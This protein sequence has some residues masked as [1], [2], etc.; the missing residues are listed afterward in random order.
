MQ[1][2]SFLCSRLVSKP[3]VFN[4]LLLALLASAILF[5]PHSTATRQ[6]IPASDQENQAALGQ[7]RQRP[8]FVHGEALVRFKQ[9]RAFEGAASLP[10]PNADALIQTQD[11]SAALAQSQEQ[12]LVN[13]DRF[14]GSDIVDGLRMARMAPDDTMKAIAALQ[15]RDD[16]LYA[17]PNYIRHVDTTTP[18]DPQFNSLYGLTKIGAQQAWDTTTGSR[19][20]VVGI[21]DEGIDINHL[22]L[23]ANIWTNPSPGSISGISGD[24]HGYDF[25]TGSG[26]IPAEPH[27][28]HVAGT[29]GAVGNN[30]IGVAGVNWQVSLMSLRFINDATGSGSDADALKAYNYAKQMRDLW[31]SSG[32][33]KGANIRAL[34]ASYGGGGY[35]Q[36]SA[37]AINALGQSGILF[38]A[39]A[40]NDGRNTDVQ[41][42]YPSDYSLSSGVSVAATNSSDNL[43]GFS[44]F[45]TRTVM[46]GAP[47]VNICSTI[48]N[49]N[50]SCSFSGT[51]MAT[52]HVT[53]AAALLCAANPNLTVN[54]LRALLSF[55]GDVVSA[56]QG[57]SLS[58]RRLN[59]FKSLQ[60]M[61]EG[62]TTPP[63]TVGGF[64]IATQNGR[65]VTLSWN[66]SGDDGAAGQAS[67]YDVSFV[68]QATS[69]VVPLTSLTPAISG[70]AQSINVNVPYRHT[71]GTFRVREFDNVG[72]EGTP[73]TISANI[74]PN[75]ADPYTSAV[76]SS[77]SL[78]TGGTPLGLTF[79]DR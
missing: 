24:L 61:N 66:A 58:G 48:P 46:L 60:A 14:E 9:N 71:A 29:I 67:L 49:N 62:D 26:T 79:D 72:N 33:T 7:K 59:V 57:K 40:G 4:C 23:Q 18:N 25:I 27:A 15:A 38:V 50:Y 37:D 55:N 36:A 20:V 22:D 8:D 68:D 11:K 32:G 35:S 2:I 31:V 69:A 21:I 5:A 65:N 63:G 34:N 77:A 17:E 30:S 78:S 19:S 16:V 1:L 47:G 45:G 64:Q 43:A 51:S 42:N 6:T 44:N 75:F 28:T 70:A 10:V 3:L 13:V 12:V 52:P 39:A 74:P 56:L 73:A 54:Q 76:N 53:G 41:P